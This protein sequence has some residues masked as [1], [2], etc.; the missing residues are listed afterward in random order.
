MDIGRTDSAAAW[1][2]Q[3]R[4]Q[5]LAV[6]DYEEEVGTGPKEWFQIFRAKNF[7]YEKI[8]MP[9]DARA[10][11]FASERSAIEQFLDAGWPVDIVPR[12]SKQH[13]ID[14]GRLVLPMS[15]FNPRCQPGIE[16]L[17]AYRRTFNEKTKQFSDDPAHDWSS[18]GSDAWRYLSLIAK[19]VIIPVQE[20]PPPPRRLVS[21]PICLDELWAER[22]ERLRIRSS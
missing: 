21:E 1:F 4:P 8:W 16:A 2:W 13:G 20:A 12:L 14:A 6:I 5:G 22:E 18:N 11:T 7:E 17:R 9:H 15:W 19:P 10:R 3:P